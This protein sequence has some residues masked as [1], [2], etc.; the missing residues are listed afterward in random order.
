MSSDV[1]KISPIP[2]RTLFFWCASSFNPSFP[3]SLQ[4]PPHPLHNATHNKKEREEW[5]KKW[6]REKRLKEKKGKESETLLR[7]CID[8][9]SCAITWHGTHFRFFIGIPWFSFFFFLS[10]GRG[11]PCR[12]YIS[13]RFHSTASPLLPP[14]INFSASSAN[15]FRELFFLFLFSSFPPSFLPSKCTYVYASLE[16]FILI[17]SLHLFILLFPLFFFIFHLLKQ[18][19]PPNPKPL[20]PQRLH[21]THKRLTYLFQNIQP[22]QTRIWREQTNKQQK[23]ETQR[24]NSGETKGMESK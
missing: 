22:Y 24:Q 16:F 15:R 12:S 6:R 1:T 11:L 20:W 7:E 23:M 2:P 18:L 9:N 19:P 8:S 21:Q 13:L 14:P 5:K 17:I 10:G 4:R 3:S